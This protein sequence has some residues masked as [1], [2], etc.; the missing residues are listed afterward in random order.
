MDNNSIFLTHNEKRK[1]TTVWKIAQWPSY[2]SSKLLLQLLAFLNCIFCWG[3]HAIC[4]INWKLVSAISK[5]YR[6]VIDLYVTSLITLF[7]HFPGWGN[8]IWNWKL[9]ARCDL[10]PIFLFLRR[11]AFQFLELVFFYSGKQHPIIQD[12]LFVHL[13][14][15]MK[16]WIW[17]AFW[18]TK[19]FIQNN[20]L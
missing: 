12:L 14:L 2:R 18:K 3:R 1:T 6:P 20:L 13:H 19:Y 4:L 17:W 15:S 5:I 9:S 16:V 7:G 8:K 11:W 10:N